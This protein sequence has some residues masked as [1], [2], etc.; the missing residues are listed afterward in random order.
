[1]IIIFSVA[2]LISP[3]IHSSCGYVSRQGKRESMEDS[4]V[5]AD[6]LGS[7]NGCSLAAVFDGHG[8]DECALWLTQHLPGYVEKEIWDAYD[9]EAR[10]VYDIND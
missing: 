5:F 4:L 9:R 10:E 7:I 1:M 2:G 6:H 8:G 3:T